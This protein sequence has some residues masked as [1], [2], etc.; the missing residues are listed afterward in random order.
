M[1]GSVKTNIGHLEAAAGVAG[2]IKTVLVLYHRE[3]PPNLHFNTPNPE[4]PWDRYPMK[5]PTRSMPLA[6]R[7]TERLC[8]RFSPRIQRNQCA[9]RVVVRPGSPNRRYPRGPSPACG[10]LVGET[11]VFAASTC[12]EFRELAGRES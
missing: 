1:I 2:L 9:C 4:I 11:S 5:V 8:R 12:G 6:S 7:R 10:D 3:I